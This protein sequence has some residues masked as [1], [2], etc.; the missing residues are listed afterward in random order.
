MRAIV[1]RMLRRILLFI[2]VVLVAGTVVVFWGL[3][4]GTVDLDLGFANFTTDLPA[5]FVATF[6]FGWLFGL[7]C[8]SLYLLRV[9]NDRRKI[10]KRLR[11]AEAEVSSLRSLPLQDTGD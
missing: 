6:V 7:V 4:P 9:A 3:N 8:A 10:R 5:A 1:A 11:H 2:V